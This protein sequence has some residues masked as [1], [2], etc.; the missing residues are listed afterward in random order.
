MIHYWLSILYLFLGLFLA[1]RNQA[2]YNVTKSP[3]K[4]SFS[5]SA[6]AMEAMSYSSS[7]ESIV[8]HSALLSLYI[9][10]RIIF[11]TLTLLTDK[12]ILQKKIT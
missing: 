4:V 12:K 7:Y 11:S 1:N 2:E 10:H 8:C 3:L 9:V 6:V 5:V